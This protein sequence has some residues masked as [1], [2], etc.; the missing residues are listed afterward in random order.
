M[1]NPWKIAF[2]SCLI[3]LIT[4]TL[5][6]AYSVLDQG[7]SLTYLRDDHSRTEA[8][9]E[10]LL[11]ILDNSGLSKQ[12]VLQKL[13]GKDLNELN[14]D[15]IYLEKVMLIFEED[16]LVKAENIYKNSFPVE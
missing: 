11:E 16:S 7:V 10:T 2:W 4:I 13:E 12:L 6:S 3:L 8:E 14:S 9:M 15:T 5:F 1:K